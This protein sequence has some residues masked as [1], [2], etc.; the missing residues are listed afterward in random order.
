MHKKGGSTDPPFL[1]M[2]IISS[3]H[4]AH[5]LLKEHSEEHSLLHIQA[6]CNRKAIYIRLAKVLPS[7][8]VFFQLELSIQEN[9]ISKDFVHFSAVWSWHFELRRPSRPPPSNLWDKLG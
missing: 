5:L 7:Y 9:S 8:R 2:I 4:H 1:I 6:Y 3:V